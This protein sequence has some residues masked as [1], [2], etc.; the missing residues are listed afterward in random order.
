M[1]DDFDRPGLSVLG[2]V[3]RHEKEADL[4]GL[5]IMVRACVDPLAA[6]TVWEKMGTHHHHDDDE[7]GAGG[8]KRREVP[9]ILST[10]PHDETRAKYLGEAAPRKAVRYHENGCGHVAE[11][12]LRMGRRALIE[13]AIQR[14][15]G[16]EDDAAEPP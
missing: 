2:L 4:L 14:E 9:A 11:H 13:E 12:V 6:V 8:K 7:D 15:A 3:A 1:T 16:S 5:D 10:H